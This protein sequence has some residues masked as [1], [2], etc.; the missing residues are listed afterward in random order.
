MLEDGDFNPFLSRYITSFFKKNGQ[1]LI[2]IDMD[3]FASAVEMGTG[4]DLTDAAIVSV[5]GKARR[6]LPGV[7]DPSCRVREKSVVFLRI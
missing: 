3:S 2:N 7:N 6:F 1:S 5:I 4:D